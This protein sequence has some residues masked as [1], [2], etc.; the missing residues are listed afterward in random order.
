MYQEIATSKYMLGAADPVRKEDGQLTQDS[1][2]VLQRWHQ[3]FCKLLNQQ[4]TFS[5]E[6]R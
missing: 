6:A 1:L 4:S 2:E 5:D 3:H